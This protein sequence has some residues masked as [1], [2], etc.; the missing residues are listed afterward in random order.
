MIKEN[1]DYRNKPS[2]IVDAYTKDGS[3]EIPHVIQSF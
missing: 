3:Q 1:F 2:F